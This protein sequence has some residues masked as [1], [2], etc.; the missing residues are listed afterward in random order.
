MRNIALIV[1]KSLELS[2]RIKAVNKTVSVRKHLLIIVV[3]T[4]INVST[5]DSILLSAVNDDCIAFSLNGL[6][7]GF[8]LVGLLSSPVD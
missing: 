6:H 5:K 2:T 4:F 7:V 1:L 3:P 8:E